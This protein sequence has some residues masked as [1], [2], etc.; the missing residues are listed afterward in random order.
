MEKGWMEMSRAQGHILAL[1]DMWLSGELMI[2]L[3]GF[4]A[5]MIFARTSRQAV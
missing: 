3:R 4:G 5:S 2:H 1:F